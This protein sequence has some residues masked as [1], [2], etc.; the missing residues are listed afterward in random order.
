[1]AKRKPLNWYQRVTMRIQTGRRV[2]LCR[3]RTAKGDN[4]VKT[5][6]AREIPDWERSLSSVVLGLGLAA[7]ILA[8]VTTAL[9]L[10]AKFHDP[11][12]AG[13]MIGPGVGAL[14]A[15]LFWIL[16]WSVLKM[17]RQSDREFYEQLNGRQTL[18]EKLEEVPGY[19][20][21][22]GQAIT[23]R[24]S[25]SVGMA[26]LPG[27]GGRVRNGF[28]PEL[29]RLA[30]SVP[31]ESVGAEDDWCVRRDWREVVANWIPEGM[32]V[33]PARR[34]LVLGDVGRDA[35]VV[36]AGGGARIEV[37]GALEAGARIGALGGGAQIVIRGDAA[38]AGFVCAMGGGA[39]VEFHSS[40][41]MDVVADGGAAEIRRLGAT[42][43]TL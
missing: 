1:M 6:D 10:D 26:A 36:A 8:I 14:V 5:R 41:S 4:V 21:I 32:T 38:K 2:V 42:G 13:A 27:I 18:S 25:E 33:G 22:P 11:S 7:I 24:C 20:G 31:V 35:T 15:F 16:A 28:E 39:R 9:G 40:P 43:G 12:A 37:M 19:D 29:M 30:E 17:W 23:G 34:I 3:S